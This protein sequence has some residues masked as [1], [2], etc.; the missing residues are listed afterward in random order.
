VDTRVILAQPA[1]VGEFI[2]RTIRGARDYDLF[3]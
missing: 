2:H 1:P 3:A